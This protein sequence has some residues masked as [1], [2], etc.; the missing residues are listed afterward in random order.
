MSE[1]IPAGSEDAFHPN[2]FGPVLLIQMMRLYDIGIALLSVQDPVKAEQLILMH[3]QGITFTP[4]PAFA[5][6]EE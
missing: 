3:E 6:D 1:Q 5:Q 4:A 2:N